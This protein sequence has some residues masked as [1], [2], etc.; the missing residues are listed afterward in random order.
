MAAKNKNWVN[1]KQIK[2][3]VSMEKILE[4]YGL[5]SGLKKKGN[6]LVGPCPIH[7]GNNP[8][9]FHASLE[10]NNFNCFGNCKSGGNILDLVSKIEDVDI[11]EAA[12]MIQGWFG[13]NGKKPQKTESNKQTKNEPGPKEKEDK[14]L[15]K[16]LTF[17]LKNLDTDHPYL[18]ER[19][20]DKE[21]IEHFG[22]GFCKKGLMANRIVIPILDEKDELVAYVGRFP[23][24]PPEDEPKYKLP[25]GFHK[26]LVIYNLHAA[27][28]L[29]VEQGLILVEGFFDCF[30][31]WQ[32]G[33]KN[34][35]S[36]MGSSL[37]KEQVSL[38]L[39]SVGKQGRVYLMFDEDESGWS[40]RKE[41]LEKL[42]PHVF[43]K[44]IELGGQGLQ[45]DC[46]SLEQIKELLQ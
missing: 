3:E 39:D 5:L 7:K 40:C 24:D 27:K 6:N 18:K 38:I 31:V 26:S 28:S 33:F 11:R 23:G 37:S 4:R 20:L 19:E 13:I 16:P 30:R 35:A 2:T 25:P 32:A 34:V 29:A 1:F 12:L 17:S 44:V 21:V 10:K 41:T 46:L 45:P 22:L 36:L 42:S 9:Q 43:V 8:T 15:N 14:P